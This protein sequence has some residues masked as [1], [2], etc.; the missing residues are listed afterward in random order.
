[1]RKYEITICDKT[2]YKCV[3]DAESEQEAEDIASATDI[4][5]MEKM[6]DAYLEI[7]SIKEVK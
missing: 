6:S 3:V 5:E 4:N 7:D 1:M 2:Y